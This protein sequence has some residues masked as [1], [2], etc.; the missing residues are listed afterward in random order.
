MRQ[1]SMSFAEDSHASP[2]ASLESGSHRR[3]R[4]GSGRSSVG[5]SAKSDRGSSSSKTCQGCGRPDCATCWPTLPLSGSMRSGRLSVLASSELRTDAPGS[6]SL[7]TTP[8]ASQYG[9][10]QGGSAGRVGPKRHNLD[11]MLPTPCARDGGRGGTM[12]QCRPTIDS[13]LPT[14]TV[15]GDWNRQS[16][17]PKS[18]DGLSTVVGG[19]I[20]GILSVRLREWMMGFPRGWVEDAEGVVE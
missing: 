7:L 19:S 16:S 5:S 20:R 10:N 9:S 1:L 13:L 6:S 4:G 11:S 2:S 12:A 18:G 8:T 15:C 17:S 3:M 14:P